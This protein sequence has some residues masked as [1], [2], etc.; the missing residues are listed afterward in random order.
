MELLQTD[1]YL[2]QRLEPRPGDIYY[3]HLADLREAMLRASR[4]P[5][6]RIIDFGCGG[7]P[8]RSYFPGAVYHRADLEGTEGVDFT[9]REDSRVPVP[10]ES[11][12]LVLSTQVLEHVR[13]VPTYLRECRRM[14]QPGGRLI[15]TTHGTFPDHACPHDYQRWTVDGLALAAG[16]AGFRVDRATKLTAGARAMV[17][18]LTQFQQEL[19]APGWSPGALYL[20]LLRMPFRW[21]RPAMERFSD[22]AFARLAVVENAP[23]TPNLYIGAMIEATRL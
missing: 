9:F 3:L 1:D 18:L 20:R 12:D 22:T 4:T 5:A 11:Y 16:N 14:L 7:S 17:F 6:R 2:R 13:D 15:V 10:D 8:Y 21:F 23:G 19:L